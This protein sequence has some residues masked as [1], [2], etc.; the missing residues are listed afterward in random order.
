MSEQVNKVGG[1]NAQSKSIDQVVN[2]LKDKTIRLCVYADTYEGN[3]YTFYF[4]DGSEF[5]IND[6]NGVEYISYG[7]F[8]KGGG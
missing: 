1:L 2:L 7:V 3:I 5:T 4:T 8:I 6:I